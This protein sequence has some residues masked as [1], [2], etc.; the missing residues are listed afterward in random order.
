M[1]NIIGKRFIFFGISELVILASVVAIALLGLN[2]GIEFSSGSLLTLR[3]VEPVSVPEVKGALVEIGYPGAIVQVTG[4]DDF[5]IRSTLLSADAKEEMLASLSASL[6]ELDEVGFESI[7]PVI[8]RET[9]RT[10]AIAVALA[11]VGIA[12]YITWAFRRMPKP[13]RYGS[14]ALIALLH[15]ILIVLGVFAVLGV[16]LG[17]EVD[18][19]FIT[20]ILAVVGYSV[21]DTVVVFDRIRETESLSPKASFTSIVNRSINAALARS[22]NTMVTTLVAVAALLLFVGTNIQTFAVTLMVGIVSG[23]YSSVFVA[24]SLLVVWEEGEWRHLLPFF[25]G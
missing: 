6:G 16:V 4:T 17:W 7:D 25:R 11:A 8:A 1:W 20:G 19:M 14:C 22:L 23:T 24:S 15:D 9:L 13:F 12:L 2:P 10:T 21:N 18:L 3:F 5:L